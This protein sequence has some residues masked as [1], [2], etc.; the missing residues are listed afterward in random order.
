MAV[1]KATDYV[2]SRLKLIERL[3]G[4]LT[5]IFLNWHTACYDNHIYITIHLKVNT[6]KSV[7]RVAGC[8]F[9]LF[10]SHAVFHFSQRG[11]YLFVYTGMT[12]H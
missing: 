7:N 12:L 10:K 2:D 5:I 1:H 9:T 8:P 6:R 11:L 4:L 3:T